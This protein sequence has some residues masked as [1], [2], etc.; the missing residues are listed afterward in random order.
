[1]ERL[2]RSP[3]LPSA[4]TDRAWTT[5]RNLLWRRFPG[6][7]LRT[8]AAWWQR[9]LFG[10]GALIFGLL[11]TIVSSVIRDYC[12]EPN[13]FQWSNGGESTIV[14]YILLFGGLV[15]LATYVF[16]VV[17]LV[18]LWPAESQRRHWY[19]MICIA[20]V[21]PPLLLGIT[22]R[23]R[24]SMFFQE[25]RRSLSIFGWLELLAL[26]SCGCYLILIHWQHRRLNARATE[27]KALK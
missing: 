10:F 4:R 22:L 27:A 23:G 15:I 24:P 7:G 14:T 18:L 13:D 1:M 19:A 25:V 26:C 2:T 17:P 16:F 20:M 11:L 5:N 8:E 9:L 21:W 6:M 12:R 3:F